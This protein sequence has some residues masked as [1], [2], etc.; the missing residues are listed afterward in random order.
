MQRDSVPLVVVEYVHSLGNEESE[1][2]RGSILSSEKC[3]STQLLDTLQV[4]IP[5]SLQKI[6][7][8]QVKAEGGTTWK[9]ATI[10]IANL[11]TD[12]LESARAQLEDTVHLW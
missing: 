6:A 2:A 10:I 12:L 8:A 1:I 4:T 11:Y 3:K 9:N 7:E 5:E